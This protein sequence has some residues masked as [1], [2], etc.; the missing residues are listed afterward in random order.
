MKRAASRSWQWDGRSIVPHR[1]GLP[2]SDR[3]FRYG[4][5]LFESIA[6]RNGRALLLREHLALLERA[7]R[8][9][10][11]PIP[12]SRSLAA[13]LRGFPKKVTLADGMLR[14]YLTAGPGA[15]ASPVVDPG[16]Y[17]TWEATAFPSER[18]IRQGIPVVHL[19]GCV[20]ERWG[21][22]SGNYASHVEALMA[23]RSHGGVEGIVTDEKGRLVSCTMGNLLLWLP[24]KRKG[25]AVPHTPGSSSGARSGAV[26]EWVRGKSDVKDSPLRISDLRRASALAVTNSRLGVMPVSCCDRRP[27]PDAAPARLL[28]MEYLQSHGLLLGS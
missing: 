10:V 6:V 23:A 2:L 18:E 13:A 11:Q 4:Q 22:K 7:A 21:E 17:L 9:G 1:E 15:P 16:C 8:E 3:G 5:H 25:E 24:G 19:E 27:L 14:I 26:L 12:F 28:A 20:G